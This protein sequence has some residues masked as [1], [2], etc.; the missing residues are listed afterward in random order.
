MTI[1]PD[2][3]T[4]I[5]GAG[6]SGIGAA[7]KLDKAGL[8]DYLIVEA[9]DGV[10]GTWYWNTYPGIAVDIP[11]FS[12]QFSFEQSAHW[13]RTYAPGRELKA[14]AEHCVEK[15]GIRSRIRFNTKV[16][17]AEFD[18]EHHVWRVQTDPGGEIT[19]RFLISA[20]GVLT[21]PN[22]PDIDGV[23]SFAGI[24]MHASPSSAPAPRPCRSSPRSRQSSSASR[25]FSG[26]RS[27]ASPSSTCH[28]RHRLAGRCASP[29]AKSS[30]GCSA[31]PSSR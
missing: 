29:A 6:F 14:Y 24:T 9:G 25:S 19:A 30:S 8:S 27:G 28:C 17:T 15:Y 12:Y 16:L 10:G 1:T 20:S 13:S 23:D 7:I 2:Y 3:D 5:V 11:S 31:R 21:V 4:L 18:D 26:H 22:L